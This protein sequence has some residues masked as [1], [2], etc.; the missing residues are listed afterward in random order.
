MPRAEQAI[1]RSHAFRYQSL[2]W[3]NDIRLLSIPPKTPT[4][5]TNAVKYTLSHVSLDSGYRYKALS[6][7]WG[8]SALSH[9]IC[10][11]ESIL[12]IAEN[13]A[14]VLEE[15]QNGDEEV[16][17]W[18]DAIC[19]NQQDAS[20]KTSQ[21]QLMRDIYKAAEEVV[22]WLG[23][24]T[25]QTDCTLQQV[26]KLGDK[27]VNLNM[28]S[29]NWSNPNMWA[30]RPTGLTDEEVRLRSG[31]MEI[32]HQHLEEIR[33]GGHPFWWIMS[34]LRTRSWFKRV[35]CIQECANARTAIFRC[36]REGVEFTRFWATA[37]YVRLF[38]SIAS[39]HPAAQEGDSFWKME[40]LTN[41]MVAAFPTDLISI[42]RQ[43][44]LSGTYNLR[45]LLHMTNVVESSTE[46]RIEATDPRDR[47]YALLGIASDPAATDIIAD[48]NVSCESVYITTAH[49][50]I[51]HGHD[52]ILSLCRTRNLYPSLP[53]WVPDWS[54]QIRKPWSTFHT[55]CFFNASGGSSITIKSDGAFSKITLQ[56]VFVDTIQE[57]GSIW[58]LGVDTKFDYAAALRYVNDVGAYLS[59]S[60]R[61]TPEERVE[62]EWRLPIGD[63]ELGTQAWQITRATPRSYM[64]EG[65]ATLRLVA[66]T[67]D[68]A[69]EDAHVKFVKSNRLPFASYMCQME[70]M[71]E[72]RPFRSESGWVGIAPSHAKPGDVVFIFKGCRV[73]YVIRNHEQANG[74]SLVGEAHVYAIMDGEFMKE[75]RPVEEITLC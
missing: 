62:A 50:L 61:Y 2:E 14:I 68:D 43:T 74:W 28:W 42:R 21:V 32:V 22:L 46:R 66:S 53:S 72:S 8:N 52:D 5:S 3:S 37:C 11:N 54:A 63:T 12:P 34:D 44:L 56:G 36:G 20:E 67:S 30:D 38:E 17:F 19:I 75:Q 18:I 16:S 58:S 70:R 31:V 51:R 4:S 71:H 35:W 47:V 27:L 1:T 13:L 15:L 65:H 24:S 26:R 23:P 41:A 64:R 55:D 45:T 73:P 39:H 40:W 69:A 29:L 59:Q 57:A 60:P 10:V 7:V 49:A 48:Y 9:G 6:Y 25:P 33:D